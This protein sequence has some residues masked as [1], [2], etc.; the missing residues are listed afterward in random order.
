MKQGIVMLMMLG[1]ALVSGTVS[2]QESAFSE[3]FDHYEAIRQ[4]LIEDSTDGVTGHATAIADAAAALAR[5]LD[6]EAAQVGAD[7]ADAVRGW[8]GEIETRARAVARAGGLE[9][10]REALAELTKPLVRWH[11]LVD[12]SKP[13]VAYCPMVEKAWL[14]PDE[15]IGNPYAPFMLRCGEVVQR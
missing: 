10:A 9:P 13:V 1:I 15:P 5:D 8:L 4:V 7:H 2:A 14:Q 6:A 12:G 3:I 11:E